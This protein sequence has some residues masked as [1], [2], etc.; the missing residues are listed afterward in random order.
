MR[1]LRTS[2]A[3]LRYE[4]TELQGGSKINKTR[5]EITVNDKG[6]DDDND[7]RR[8]VQIIIIIIITILKI[9]VYSSS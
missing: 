3:R 2:A 4:E 8:C 7:I 9:K 5:S 6:D 1:H